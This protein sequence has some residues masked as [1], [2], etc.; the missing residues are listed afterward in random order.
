MQA[1]ADSVDHVGEAVSVNWEEVDLVYFQDFALPKNKPLHGTPPGCFMAL[2]I[3]PIFGFQV[4]PVLRCKEKLSL[5]RPR[6]AVQNW[7]KQA[8]RNG[9]IDLS[10]PELGI[11]H[12][13]AKIIRITVPSMKTLSSGIPAV[14]TDVVTGVSVRHAINTGRYQFKEE[15]TGRIITINATDNHRFY[16]KNKHTFIPIKEVSPGDTLI[17]A[18]G[19]SVRLLCHKNHLHHCA[20]NVISGQPVPVYNLEV[21]KRH[22]YFVSGINILV[23]NDCN[24][25]IKKLYYDEEKTKIKYDGQVDEETGLREGFGTEFSLRGHK[26]YEG[27]WHNDLKEGAGITYVDGYTEGMLLHEGM[28]L[29]GDFD[30]PGIQY[31]ILDGTIQYEGGFEK[32]RFSGHGTLYFYPGMYEGE[33][34]RAE[35]QGEFKNGYRDGHG[36]LFYVE[37]GKMAFSGFWHEGEKH[38]QGIAYAYP[39]EGGRITQPGCWKNNW[40]MNDEYLD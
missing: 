20:R 15:T 31:Y 4:E 29:E 1:A 39:K 22:V 3:L 23:H 30:G 26:I 16:V 36:V 9:F 12:M 27:F 5:L 18:T 10:L 21:S 2:S 8:S 40:W 33:E 37:N 7:K 11:K 19:R 38:G 34:L 6:T 25:I 32:G 14:S 35:Y 17:T 28:Y 13:E 24:K